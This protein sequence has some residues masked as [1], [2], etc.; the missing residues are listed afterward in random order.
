[1]RAGE[2]HSSCFTDLSEHQI[3]GHNKANAVVSLA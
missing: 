2:T 1:M 3:N